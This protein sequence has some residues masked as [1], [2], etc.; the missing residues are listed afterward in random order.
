MDSLTVDEILM[1]ALNV[2]SPTVNC[3]LLTL[4]RSTSHNADMIGYI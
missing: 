2:S 4:L 3:F 1:H